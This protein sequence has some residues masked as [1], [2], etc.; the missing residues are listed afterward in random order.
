MKRGR[1]RVGAAKENI[2]RIYALWY[3]KMEKNENHQKSLPFEFL[4]IKRKKVERSG[5]KGL[6]NCEN[7]IKWNEKE[8]RFSLGALFTLEISSIC[9]DFQEWRLQGGQNL[10]ICEGYTSGN[11]KNAKYKNLKC[12]FL[13]NIFRSHQRLSD[14]AC[15]KRT[16]LCL[17]AN[18]NR[19]LDRSI[20]F[21]IFR[22]TGWLIDEFFR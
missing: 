7:E 6:E 2:Q 15:R 21:I 11:S 3:D 12:W 5:K 8:M 10:F 18:S 9:V 14:F 16:P 17:P 13:I 4:N 19:S 20:I 1:E 22:R